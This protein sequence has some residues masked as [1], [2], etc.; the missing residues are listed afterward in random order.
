MFAPLL[1]LG[2]ESLAQNQAGIRVACVGNSITQ[3]PGRES[4][5][6]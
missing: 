4:I 1:M 3:G 5:N 6:S 2:V